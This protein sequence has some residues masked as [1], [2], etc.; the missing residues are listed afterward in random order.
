MPGH[1]LAECRAHAWQHSAKIVTDDQGKESQVVYADSQHMIAVV[2]ALDH[3][4]EPR[5]VSILQ[6][7][8]CIARQALAKGFGF[9]FQIAAQSVLLRLH[10]IPRRG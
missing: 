1:C 2:E 7:R 9:P 4:F 10:L 3:P 8:L 5:Q 6:E